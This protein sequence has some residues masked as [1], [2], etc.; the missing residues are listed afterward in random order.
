MRMNRRVGVREGTLKFR[1]LLWAATAVG[2]AGCWQPVTV[3]PP[4]SIPRMPP[5]VQMSPQISPL[6]EGPAA[7]AIVPLQPLPAPQSISSNPWKPTV[8]P[9]DWKYIVIHHT[10][11]ESG[12]VAS[13]H[14]THLQR[15]DSSGKNWLGIGYHF[16]I[17]NGNGMGDGE[18]EPTFRWKQQMHGA[19]AG[20]KEHNQQGIGIALVGNFEDKPPSP[21]Q[22]DAIKRL[23]SVLKADYGVSNENV[24]GHG[25]I[26]ATACPG[27][28]FPLEEVSRV[29][30]VAFGQ[31]PSGTPLAELS[32]RDGT[33]P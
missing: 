8:P 29:P 21:K 28:H 27:K 15:K 11:A 4:A 32:G 13:I 17:G 18:I 2:V 7:P 3:P 25:D 14:E 19:H 1:P 26:K 5:P 24:I 10:A 31:L 33:T 23:V 20:G 30:A 12:D 6:P 16:V 22:L 9:R